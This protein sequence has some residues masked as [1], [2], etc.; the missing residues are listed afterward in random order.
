MKSRNAHM[1]MHRQQTSDSS[2]AMN[3]ISSTPPK[4]YS[5]PTISHNTPSPI[6]D[7]VTRLAPPPPV[8]VPISQT[9]LP[10]IPSAVHHSSTP[11]VC[12]HPQFKFS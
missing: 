2:A 3:S 8:H 11:Q 4:I 5:V 6:N 1:K 10:G 12:T 9:G 7:N